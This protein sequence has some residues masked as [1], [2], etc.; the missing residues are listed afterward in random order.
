MFIKRDLSKTIRDITKVEPKLKRSLSSIDKDFNSH[1]EGIQNC[2]NKLINN[3]NKKDLDNETRDKITKILMPRKKVRREQTSFEN[4]HPNESVI[5][6]I[7]EEISK[8]LRKHDKS[9]LQAQKLQIEA[10]VTNNKDLM[11]DLS[12]K[13]ARLDLRQK[14]LWLRIQDH[15]DLW[16]SDDK[17]YTVRKKGPVL[18]LAKP[19]KAP[20]SPGGGGGY[21]TPHPNPGDGNGNSESVGLI[22][23]SP[24]TLKSFFRFMDI[25]PP[26][27]MFPEEGSNE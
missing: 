16:N 21:N 11:I 25:D 27:G 18:V 13:K 14:K 7:P 8:E 15:F 10:Q 3:L 20:P 9:I 1:V 26:P 23:M 22:S 24:E 19:K 17:Y 12:R 2:W 4:V 6:A 5:G